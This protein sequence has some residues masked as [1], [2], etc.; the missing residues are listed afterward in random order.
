MSSVVKKDVYPE[1]HIQVIQKK[2]NSSADVVLQGKYS[3]TSAW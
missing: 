1:M 3:L 2:S